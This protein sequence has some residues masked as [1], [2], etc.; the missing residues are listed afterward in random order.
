MDLRAR[1]PP[2]RQIAEADECWI[3]HNELPS[4]GLPDFETLR[5]AHTNACLAAALQG[6]SLPPV[7]ASHLPP[8]HQGTSPS[9]N[10][11]PSSQERPGIASSSSSPAPITNTPEARTAAREQAHAAIVLGQHRASPG[12]R[13]L[14]GGTIF[15]YKASEK[16][17]IQDAECSICFD[18]YVVGQDM[19]RLECFC[20]FHL[21]CIRDWYDK[22]PGKCPMHDHNSDG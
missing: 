19:G 22:Q 12:P 4:R 1:P 7:P 3:C 14:N 21:R 20:R 16:D 9:Q 17:L 8:A 11:G 5:E 6:V 15:P 18:E 10:A 2:R 13:R